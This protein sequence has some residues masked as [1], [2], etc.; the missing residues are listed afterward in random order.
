MLHKSTYRLLTPDV[1]LDKDGSDAQEQF[2]AGVYERLGS[3]VLPRDLEDIGLENAPQYDLYE[4]KMHNE[5]TFSQLAE[6]LEPMSEAGDQYIE[7]EIM[8]PRRDEM[9]R[10]H[11]VT[12]SHDASGN[13]MGAAQANPIMDTRLYQVEFI[14]FEVTE[15]TANVIAESMYAQCDADKNEYLLLDVLV[16]YLK[17]NKAIFLTDQQITVWGRPVTQKTTAG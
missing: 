17:D 8:F 14:G 1:V 5:Q 11:V 2:M 13:I 6:E 3:Q 16:D 7:A 9:A 4:D 15:L 12:Q 10:D